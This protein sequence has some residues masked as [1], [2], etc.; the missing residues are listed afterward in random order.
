MH[1]VG[2]IAVSNQLYEVAVGVKRRGGRVFVTRPDLPEH[3][4]T[5]SA[6]YRDMFCGNCHGLGKL[7]LQVIAGGPFEKVPATNSGGE[8]T[9]SRATYMDGRWYLQK[10]REHTCPI[11][12]GSGSRQLPKPSRPVFVGADDHARNF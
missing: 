3:G 8:E 9:G 7:G 5:W 1:Y 4:A 10:T 2:E 12:G 6:E 11:C